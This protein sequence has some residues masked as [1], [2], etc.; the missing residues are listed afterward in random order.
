MS[1]VVTVLEGDA[2]KNFPSKL[3]PNNPFYYT[4]HCAAEDPHTDLSNEFRDAIINP[5]KSS[6]LIKLLKEDFNSDIL[7]RTSQAVTIFNSGSKSN[8]LPQYAEALV[9][10]RISNEQSLADIQTAL[11]NSISPVAKKHGMFNDS[12]SLGH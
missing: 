8:A 4:L 10:Y 3:T 5:K 12:L 9:N 1:D 7:L 11:T 6:E 2:K